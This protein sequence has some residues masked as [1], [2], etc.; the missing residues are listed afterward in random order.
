MV[1]PRSITMT[2]LPRSVIA[3]GIPNPKLHR[4]REIIQP[5]DEHD[6]DLSNEYTSR[7][8]A[9][10]QGQLYKLFLPGRKGL[11]RH[12]WDIRPGVSEVSWKGQGEIRSGDYTVYYSGG[13][14]AE[15]GVAIVVHKSVVRSV[16]K[17]IVCNDRIIALELKAEPVD[18]LIMQVYTPT[19]EYD[20]DEVEEVY[21]TIEEILQE[22]GR[23]DTNSIILG[24]WNS[25]VGDESYQNIVGSHGLG[26]RNHKGQML[27]DFCDFVDWLLPTLGL[28]SQREDFTHGRH[29]GIEGGISRTTSL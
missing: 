11:Q 3:C 8:G 21:D 2:V 13:E 16:V 5:Q 28:R 7:Q 23:G 18:I 10:T 26:R 24:D 25:T 4:C 15:R 17:K 14:Q 9:P 20:D 29:L 12:L 6:G 27:I 1:E 22:D 19:S